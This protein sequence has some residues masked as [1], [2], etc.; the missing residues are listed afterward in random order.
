MAWVVDGIMSG[1]PVVEVSGTARAL[2]AVVNDTDPTEV[3]A[4]NTSLAYALYE[5]E[6]LVL[7]GN[8]VSAAFPYLQT[9]ITITTALDPAKV[10]RAVLTGT[11]VGA[12]A[13]PTTSTISHARRE[14]AQTI[15]AR[16]PPVT[17][18]LLSRAVPGPAPTAFGDGTWQASISLA[19]STIGQRVLAKGLG[20]LL[21]P[22]ALY[23]ACLLLALANVHG[24]LAGYG[25][26][27]ARAL[28][29]DYLTRYSVEMERIGLGWDRDSDGVADTTAASDGGGMGAL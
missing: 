11:V 19:W 4:S 15:P 7:S 1:W 13:S 10:Y 2:F 12:G 3:W 6:T 16:R 21:T 25:S 5:G 28:R 24:Y 23:D 8:A 17:P 29:D 20:D 27:T 18:T 26:Q 22:G 9:A 14:Y